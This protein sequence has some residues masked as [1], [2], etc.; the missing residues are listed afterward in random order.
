MTT[1]ITNDNIV[2]VAASKLTGAM[3]ALDGSALTSI[4][5]TAEDAYSLAILN[6]F[7][8]AKNHD[9]ATG[10]AGQGVFDEFSADTLETSTNAT[11]SASNDSYGNAG[12]KSTFSYTGGNQVYVVPANTTTL[13]FKAWGAAGGGGNS[14]EKGGGG[15]YVME[16]LSVTPGES[17]NIKVGGGGTRTHSANGK[18]GG[19]GWTS[20]DRSATYLAG[21]GA[22]GGATANG[23]AAPGGGTTGGGGTGNNGFGGTQSAGGASGPGGQAGSLHQGGNSPAGG[24]GGSIAPGGYNG[25]G[26]GYNSATPSWISGGGGGGYYGGGSGPTGSTDTHGNGGGGS[27]LAPTGTN[28]QGSGA[29]AASIDDVDYPGGVGNSLGAVTGQHGYAVVVLAP[30]NVTLISTNAT[31]TA[32]PTDLRFDFII[33]ETDA[34]TLGTDITVK[35]SRDGGTTYTTATLTKVGTLPTGESHIK[36]EVVVSGQPSG[37]A[38]KYK[39][40][41]FNTKAMDVKYVYQLPIYA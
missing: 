17:L 4:T 34:F 5:G 38:M 28:T 32:D 33:T 26:S 14:S 12:S 15:G 6:R 24:S 41:T 23:Q 16:S 2:S 21:A 18:G 27:G 31:I 35:G 11:Y 8:I 10:T 40:E 19:G 3:P 22:G 9:L 39:L 20:I 37:T 36:A 29:I 13:T 7:E 30:A 25:G 1:K